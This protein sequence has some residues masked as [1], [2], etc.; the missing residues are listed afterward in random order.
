MSAG[1]APSLRGMHR[2]LR[3]L[4]CDD[5]GC[6]SIVCELFHAAAKSYPK[7]TT[8]IREI[9]FGMYRI[10]YHVSDDR[11]EI[12]TVYHGARLLDETDL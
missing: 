12:L 4:S 1:F 6:L 10:I 9:F 7:S 11:I 3:P 2:R 8:P 5:C